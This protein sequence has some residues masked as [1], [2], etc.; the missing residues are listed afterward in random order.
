VPGVRPGSYQMFPA[1]LQTWMIF[2][3]NFLFFRPETPFNFVPVGA[4]PAGRGCKTGIW[5]MSVVQLEAAR[6]VQKR[7]QLEQRTETEAAAE[8]PRRNF[9]AKYDRNHNGVIDPDDREEALDDPAFIESELDAIDTNHNGRLDPEEL[10]YFDANQNKI[11]EP[12]E[13]AGID[14]AQ[15]LLA[16]KLLKQFD[17]NGD[18][19]LNRNEFDGL[20][21]SGARSRMP[22][23]LDF[24]I[25]DANHDG[26]VDLGELESSLK[27]QIHRELQPRGASPAALFNPMRSEANSSVDFR[28]LFKTAV[29]FYWQK[30]GGITNRTSFNRESPPGGG[31]ITNETQNNR[32][33]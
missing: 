18:N 3:T 15:H 27:Q 30:P 4:A 14:I 28:Q 13:Q 16:T 21:Q 31:A 2:S 32:T 29:E 7:I 25:S 10:V 5:E 1:R 11:L 19:F 33:Y 12:K 9:L 8:Q 26:R 20:V 24:M 23:G 22:S 17:V 6:A